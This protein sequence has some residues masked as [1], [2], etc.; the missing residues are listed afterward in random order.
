MLQSLRQGAQSRIIKIFVF[1]TL[2]LAMMGLAMLD[3]SGFIGR[4]M[5][6][7][8][9]IVAN[10]GGI[11]IPTMEV[12]R[13]VSEEI[14]RIQRSYGA[15]LTR[16]QAI[17]MGMHTHILSRMVDETLLDRAAS[18]AGFASTDAMVANTI[19][20]DKTFADA[21]GRFDQ[22]KFLQLLGNAG[23]TAEGFADIL[24]KELPR[25]ALIRSMAN[26]ARVPE[27][28][29]DAYFLATHQQRVAQTMMLT[30]LST[31]GVKDASDAEIETRYNAHPDDY[32]TPEY[33]ALRIL[34]LGGANFTPDAAPEE[35]E[36]KT[37][38]SENEDT[39]YQREQRIAVQAILDNSEMAA[40]VAA[41]VRSGTVMRDAVSAAG[42]DPAK[43][44]EMGWLSSDRFAPETREI[45]FSMEKDAVSDPIAAGENWVVLQIKD[46]KPPRQ[47][48]F[49][50][51][52]DSIAEAVRTQKATDTLYDAVNTIDDML[53]SGKSLEEVA[54]KFNL[55]LRD[56]VAVDS[57]GKL[58][59]T[60][61]LAGLSDLR[62]ALDAAFVLDAGE[63]TSLVENDN[64]GFA[65]I[66]VRS[67]TPPSRLPLEKVRMDIARSL[68]REAQD[69]A[70]AKRAEAAVAS[71]REGKPM[72]D[73]A[74]RNGTTAETSKAMTFDGET[75][76]APEAVSALFNLKAVGDVEAVETQ[77]GRMLVRLAEIIPATL[78]SDPEALAAVRRQLSSGM[79]NDIVAAFVDE[80]KS[81]YPV[82]VH[83]RT[84]DLVFPSAAPDE[85]TSGEE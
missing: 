77:E 50:E 83:Q 54:A 56:V 44:L 14:Q 13:R 62:G 78:G 45:A 18:A 79:G 6:G 52:R 65:V 35:E 17:G 51:V 75:L 4:S 85:D 61:P 20:A 41:S 74:A 31:P 68:R 24:R 55:G 82:T 59:D 36:L 69:R 32:M 7:P 72:N 10:V 46:I 49:E 58:P 22:Q 40:K 67:I 73:V 15:N 30:D 64:N 71:I 38:Y 57:A 53:S 3:I 12:E 25:S 48:P 5:D 39:Y 27:G 42:G 34:E 80:L 1:G 26:A 28:L 29:A 19:R 66:E 63:N 9:A 21:N 11:D 76:L 81:I 33:R 8:K 43:V 60:T 23:L 70:N 2:F 84:L 37:Y 16:A 47:V